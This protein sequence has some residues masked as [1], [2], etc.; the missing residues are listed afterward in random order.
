MAASRK[1]ASGRLGACSKLTAGSKLGWATSNMA[2]DA[3]SEQ[4]AIGRRQQT[5]SSRDQVACGTPLG[6]LWL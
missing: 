1:V 6:R 5:E 4:H 3:G 2:A